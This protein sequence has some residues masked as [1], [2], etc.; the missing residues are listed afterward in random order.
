M[1]PFKNPVAYIFP[2]ESTSIELALTKAVPFICFAH[3]KIP[4]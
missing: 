1:V 3:E 4:F 2:F